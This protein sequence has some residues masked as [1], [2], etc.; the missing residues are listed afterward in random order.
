VPGRT[1]AISR[2]VLRVLRL[3]VRWAIAAVAFVAA[4]YG[5]AWWNGRDASAIYDGEPEAQRELARGVDR[6]VVAPLDR[7]DFPTGDSRFDGE[8]LFVTRMMAAIGYAQ[9][10]V[11]HPELKNEMRPRIERCLVALTDPRSRAFDRE[12][13]GHDALE[14]LG[15]DRAHAAYLGYLALAIMVAER[16]DPETRF[17]ELGDRIVAHLSR[18][19]AQSSIGLLQSYPGE[20]Y[21]I[22]NT[23]FLGAWGLHARA[24][25]DERAALRRTIAGLRRYRHPRSGLLYQAA[26]PDDGAPVDLPRGSG[27][28]LGAYFLSFADGE[29]SRSLYDAM[30]REL[31]RSHAGFGTTREYLPGEGG[32]GDVDSGPVLMGQGLSATGFTLALA[33]AHGDRDTFVRTY[34]TA[35]FFG[36]PIDDDGRHYAMGGPIGDSLLFA[37]CTAQPPE[38]WR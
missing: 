20:I 16:A 1:T 18:L 3:S 8:W 4:L 10:A 19:M 2:V 11:E 13:W 9:I 14:D 37:L 33:R 6:W 34:A 17:A 24:H 28:A 12:A 30:A 15:S 35:S 32:W 31:L 36:G 7:S 23:A 26:D 22:D 5:L 29:I 25:P 38:R 27:T 21:P